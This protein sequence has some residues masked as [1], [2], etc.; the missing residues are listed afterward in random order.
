MLRDSR[1]IHKHMHAQLKRVKITAKTKVPTANTN[2]VHM[3][4]YRC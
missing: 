4:M 3:H 1:S 2:F